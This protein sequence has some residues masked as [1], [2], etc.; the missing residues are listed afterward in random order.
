MDFELLLFDRLNAIKDTIK[1]YG[2]ENF[3]LSFSGG[4]DSTILHYLI[5]MAIP[6]NKIPRVYV[7]TGIGLKIID[8]FV[9]NLSQHDNRIITIKPQ[10]PIKQTLEKYGY[11]FKSKHHSYMVEKYQRLGMIKGVKNYLGIGDNSI[12]RTCPKKLKYQFTEEFH[13]K[14]SDLCCL[15]MKEEPM[16]QWAKENN[17]PI[18]ITGI[19]PDEGGRRIKAQCVIVKSKQVKFFNPL[20]KIDKDF[21][22]WFI[23]KY[24]LEICQIYYPPYNFKRTGCVGC[25]FAINL[26]HELDIL[27]DKF[28]IERQRCEIIWKP[29]YEEYRRIRY[30]LRKEVNDLLPDLLKG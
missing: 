10:I 30:R 25:P 13:I 17:K 24:N 6:E 19:I 28:P 3:Y 7:N 18:A 8:D 26:Q 2:E 16:T 9:N 1:K 5:D 29:V 11:P 12:Q 22:D 20:V 4:K 21:E 23:E 27:K 14:I 15:K